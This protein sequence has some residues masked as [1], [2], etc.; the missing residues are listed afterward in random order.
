MRLGR[1]RHGVPLSA[2]ERLAFVPPIT[3]LPGAPPFVL[4]AVSVGGEA[5]TVV[6]LPRLLGAADG[7]APDAPA[8]RLLIARAGAD[9]V[10]VRVDGV[11]DTFEPGRI[12]EAVRR[13]GSWLGPE[14]VRG[15]ADGGLL[16]LDLARVLADPRLRVDQVH[17][18]ETFE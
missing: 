7:A 15:V 1:E 14:H 8:A 9:R 16:L 12:D 3:P 6:D 11:E 18:E 13:P 4:G 17:D 5:L 10:A 2:V